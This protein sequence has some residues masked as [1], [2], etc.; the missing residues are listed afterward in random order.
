MTKEYIDLRSDT[1]TKP[2]TTM[3]KVMTEAEVGDDVY[4]EDPTVKKLED[5]AAQ[6]LGK[7]A[8][9]FVSSGT[10]GNL[11]AVLTH[12]ARGDE[13]ILEESSHIFAFEVGGLAALAGV[14]PNTIKGEKGKISAEQLQKA[15]KPENIHYPKPTLL[16]LENSSNFGGGTVLT[17]EE[18]DALTETAHKNNLKVHLDGARIFNAAVSLNV[19][20][21]RLVKDVD[22]IMFCLSKGLGCPVG[23]MLAGSK[24]FIERARKYR[25]M[26]GGGLRQAGVL[27]AAGI[28]SLEQLVDRLADDHV[29]ARR[30]AEGINQIPGLSVDLNTVET[31]I[32]MADITK[33]GLTSGKLSHFMQEE[34]ILVITVN[35]KRIRLVT[36]R[37]VSSQDIET[38]LAKIKYIMSNLR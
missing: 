19:P 38:A 13:I 21:S 3:R 7:E 23:S 31:N 20:V 36:H 1:L 14:M 15:I 24:E 28:Y 4:G 30:L 17:L 29:A 25:K 10:M 27:A 5:M 6:K 37:D 34:G 32:V 22:S 26:L 2:C 12:T 18:M 11:I 8:A 9:L 16:C 35:E 33:E